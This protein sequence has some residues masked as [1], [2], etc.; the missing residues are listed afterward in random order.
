MTRTFTYTFEVLKAKEGTDAHEASNWYA[1]KV[2]L[3]KKVTDKMEERDAHKAGY[4]A[5]YF[6]KVLR[7][8]YGYKKSVVTA[9]RVKEA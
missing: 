7:E 1:E 5:G 4:A 6:N 9:T 3:T 2:T 8:Q